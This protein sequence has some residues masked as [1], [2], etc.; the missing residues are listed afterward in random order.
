MLF[1]KTHFGV[2]AISLF[3]NP[4]GRLQAA[5]EYNCAR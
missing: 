3:E 4:A 5:N 2:H 1:G